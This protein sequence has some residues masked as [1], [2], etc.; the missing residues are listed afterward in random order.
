MKAQHLIEEFE[1]GEAMAGEAWSHDQVV[2]II[3][4]LKELTLQYIGH[5]KSP[6]RLQRPSVHKAI[7][8]S[9]NTRWG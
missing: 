3:K 8:V 9:A 5:T 2:G 6:K 1:R 4:S 7:K